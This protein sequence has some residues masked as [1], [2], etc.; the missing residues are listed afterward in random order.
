MSPE[1]EARGTQEADGAP[2]AAL[3]PERVAVVH[4]FGDTRFA[5][6]PA[7]VLMV[8]TDPEAGAVQALAQA[9]DLPVI[10]SLRR[11]AGQTYEIRWFTANAEL[12]LCGHGTVAASYWLFSNGWVAGARIDYRCRSGELTATLERGEVALDLPALPTWSAEADLAESV[13]AILGIPLIDVRRAA[14]DIV[15][16]ASSERD[17]VD[18]QPDIMAVAELNCRGLVVSAAAEGASSS[19]GFDFVSRFFAP[20]IAID[21]DEVCVSA[22]CKLF[23]YWHEV[24]GRTP[25]VAW[26][27]SAGGGRLAGGLRGE[28]VAIRGPARTTRRL[29]CGAGATDGSAALVPLRF[30][31][32][33]PMGIGTVMRMVDGG[34]TAGIPIPFSMASFEVKPG[35]SSEPH[36]HGSTEIWYAVRGSGEVVVDGVSRPFRAGDAVLLSAFS[37]HQLRNTGDEP[38]AA[39]S[40]FWREASG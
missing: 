22:H 26:Q 23:P 10:A 32:I 39:L 36:E 20:R 12:D 16:I 13:R 4:A 2:S 11:L 7:G 33:E 27:A 1:A 35:C 8:V 40:L 19:A 24:T 37:S 18:L 28:R 6:N 31:E 30:G 25:L 21:E 38:F 29:A 34:A 15:A 9:M 17:V 14:D 5:G 3:T